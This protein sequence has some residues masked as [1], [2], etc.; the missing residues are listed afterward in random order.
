MAKRGSKKWIFWLI[1]CIVLVVMLATIAVLAINLKEEKTTT[2]EIGEENY[3]TGRLD[4][5]GNYAV[6]DASIV[7]KDAIKTDGLT[8]VI[9]GDADIK[10]QIFFYKED[11]VFISATAELTESFTADAVPDGALTAKIVIT[12]LKDED[13]KITLCE[14]IDYAQRL[15]VQVKKDKVEA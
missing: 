6:C 8:C 13:G 7:M 15:N 2:V 11:G 5:L 1:L 9:E 14:G 4:A 10:Y 12:P 3:M